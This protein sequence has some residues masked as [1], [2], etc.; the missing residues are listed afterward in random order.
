[1]KPRQRPLPER[2][3][4][5]F[6]ALTASTGDHTTRLRGDLRRTGDTLSRVGWEER[7]SAADLSRGILIAIEGIDGAG[8]STQAD[9]VQAELTAWGMK[10]LRSREPTDGPSGQALR[11]SAVVGRLPLEREVDL[12]LRDRQEHVREKIA[13]GLARGEIVL[14]DRY[15]FSTIAYQ[16]ARGADPEQLRARNETFAPRPDLLVILDLDPEA[17]LERVKRRG[18]GGPDLFEQRSELERARAL[19]LSFAAEP[20]A[21]CLDALRPP[22]DLT[23]AILDRLLSDLQGDSR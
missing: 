8:K 4:T 18:R 21:L 7:P 12:F 20:W 23:A 17:G 13:P 2:V 10:V 19:F 22:E 11:H 1:M 3:T 9:A 5:I 15:Y 6:K 16:G 14:L